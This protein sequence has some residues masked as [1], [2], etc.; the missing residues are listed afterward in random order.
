MENILIAYPKCSTCKKAKKFLV[1]KKICFVER[2]ITKENPTKEEIKSWMAQGKIDIKKFFN[3]SGNKYKELNLKE[4]LPLMTEDEMLNV[5]SSDGMLVKRP[6]L[7]TN[8]QILIGFKINQW[9][10]VLNQD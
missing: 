4:K 8:N 10:Q 6:I 5:L 9:E 2:D 3:S 1:E 7:V